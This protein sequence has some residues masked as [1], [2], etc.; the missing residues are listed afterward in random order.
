MCNLSTMFTQAPSLQ[1]L[2][3]AF[4]EYAQA[5]PQ[6]NEVEFKC[7]WLSAVTLNTTSMILLLQMPF[8]FS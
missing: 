8:S 1:G 4:Y 5:K 7:N 3:K 6:A 2:K